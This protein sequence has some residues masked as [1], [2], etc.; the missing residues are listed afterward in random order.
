MHSAPLDSQRGD[1]Y[2]VDSL[3]PGDNPDIPATPAVAD[4][5]HDGAS[6]AEQLYP[7]PRA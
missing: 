4:K 2:W 6:I 1:G 3:G 7:F 5:L